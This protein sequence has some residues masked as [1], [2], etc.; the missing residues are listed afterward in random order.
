MHGSDVFIVEQDG[1]FWACDRGGYYRI[2]IRMHVKTEEDLKKIVANC[3]A[4]EIDFLNR[5]PEVHKCYDTLED[6]VRDRTGDVFFFSKPDALLVLRKD[7]QTWDAL[8]LSD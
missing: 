1:R 7:N 6:V 3:Y 4:D 5:E 8:T 2:A